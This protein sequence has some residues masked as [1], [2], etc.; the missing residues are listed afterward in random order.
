MIRPPINRLT[1]AADA[2]WTEAEFRYREVDNVVFRA[3]QTLKH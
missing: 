3:S 1:I 2:T